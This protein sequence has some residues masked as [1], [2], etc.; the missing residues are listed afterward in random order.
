M[1]IFLVRT[2]HSRFFDIFGSK[3]KL[4]GLIAI[5]R[6]SLSLVLSFSP[7]FVQ[8]HLREG[9]LFYGDHFGQWS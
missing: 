4:E 1:P 5:G 9:V 3:N 6:L 2:L 7:G 8:F